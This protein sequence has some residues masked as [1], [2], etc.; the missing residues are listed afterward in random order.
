MGRNRQHLKYLGHYRFLFD[1]G[2]ELACGICKL[3]ITRR[4]Q[5]TVD[6]IHALSTGGSNHPYNFQPAHAKC[7]NRRG[8]RPLTPY[9]IYKEIA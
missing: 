6:H 7:N 8:N 5:I 1:R 4:E 2:E 3:P 9:H